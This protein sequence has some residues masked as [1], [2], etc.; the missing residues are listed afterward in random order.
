MMFRQLQQ[1]I[2]VLTATTQ[3]QQSMIQRLNAEQTR[4]QNRLRQF[5]AAVNAAA[6]AGDPVARAIRSPDPS[7]ALDKLTAELQTRAH[8]GQGGV[9]S[10][11]TDETIPN[12]TNARLPGAIL[13]GVRLAKANLTGADLTGADLTNAVLSGAILRGAKLQGARLTGVN[14]TNADLKDALYD[15]HTQWP[16]GFVPTQRGALLVQ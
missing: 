7:I 15:A 4:E 11:E 16:A 3:R 12:L 13:H 2:Q 8:P 6:A 1:R 5:Q 10:A 14:L 9:A